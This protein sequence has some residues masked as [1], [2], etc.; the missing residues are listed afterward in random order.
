MTK[1]KAKLTAAEVVTVE[2]PGIQS[3]DKRTIV[4]PVGFYCG[5]CKRKADKILVITLAD[6][7][8]MEQVQKEPK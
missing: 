4:I 6:A 5:V 2:C 1:P 7:D 8:I 3:M